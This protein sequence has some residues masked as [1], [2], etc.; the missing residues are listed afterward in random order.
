M[1]TVI[2]RLCHRGTPTDRLIVVILPTCP[3]GRR[4]VCDLVVHLRS[5]RKQYSRGPVLQLSTMLLY[6]DRLSDGRRRC[7]QFIS[8][9]NTWIRGLT[10]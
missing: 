5:N 1:K 3:E 2:G 7:Q 4:R 9:R 8:R 6:Y 10:L